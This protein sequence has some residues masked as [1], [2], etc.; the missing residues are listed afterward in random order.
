MNNKG[1]INFVMNTSI[2]NVDRQQ[3]SHM[4]NIHAALRDNTEL[5]H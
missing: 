3:E 1:I 5:V 4:L 2:I